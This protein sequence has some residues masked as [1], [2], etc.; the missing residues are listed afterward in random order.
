[1]GG[2]HTCDRRAPPYCPQGA[3]S[4]TGLV[5]VGVATGVFSC[6]GRW[7]QRP[8][9]RC[10]RTTTRTRPPLRQVST[11]LGAGGEG[12][13]SRR[14]FRRAN[15]HK[16]RPRPPRTARATQKRRR[17]TTARRQHDELS[18][19]LDRVPAV[20][21]QRFCS[22]N[23][24]KTAWSRTRQTPRPAAPVPPAGQ[25]RAASIY[26]CSGCETR[27][28]GQQW[29]PDCN[30]P[31]TRVGLGGACPHCE[32]PIAINDLFDTNHNP[33]ERLRGANLNR[34]QGEDFQ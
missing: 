1:M 8:S 11:S 27:Y 30:Q 28:L 16:P 19:L 20:G 2:R 17:T 6:R 22:G 13:R 5:P 24:R 18:R 26:L 4:E 32:E 23:C 25:L 15:G 7:S 34:A 12:S 9:P 29:C 10:Y 33:Q 31:C 21:R 14:L 3:W